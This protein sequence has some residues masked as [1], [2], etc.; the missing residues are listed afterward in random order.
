[1]ANLIYYNNL[2]VEH[3]AFDREG[4]GVNEIRF[5]SVETFTHIIPNLTW[6]PRLLRSGSSEDDDSS[7]D[8]STN[9]RLFVFGNTQSVQ[10][11]VSDCVNAILDERAGMARRIVDVPTVR[12]RKDDDFLKDSEKILAEVGKR[13]NGRREDELNDLIA[14]FVDDAPSFLRLGR[15]RQMYED[16]LATSLGNVERVSDT[17]Y[18]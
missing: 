8:P 18:F 1:M 4:D 17:Y 14:S 2:L 13:A 16:T 6:Y 7:D 5:G 3:N 9:M 11:V 15:F 12:K 10:S